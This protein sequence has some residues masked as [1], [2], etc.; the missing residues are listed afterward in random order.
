MRLSKFSSRNRPGKYQTGAEIVEFLVTL[1]VVLIVLGIVFDFGVAF[2]DQS[3]LTHASRAAARA[4]IHGA[5]NDEAQ[6]AADLITS[7]LL[8]RQA[9]DPLPIVTVD[10]VDRTGTNPGD[11]ATIVISHNYVFFLLP[12]FLGGIA[13]INLS[14]TTVMNMMPN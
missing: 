4:V 14:A 1:P 10:P 11:P 5:T 13:D 8:S 9:T 2:S 6:T 7:S 3:I 12:S